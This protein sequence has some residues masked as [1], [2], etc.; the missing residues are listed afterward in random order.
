MVLLPAVRMI[1]PEREELLGPLKSALI[2]KV[3]EDEFDI[4]ELNELL[5]VD[6]CSQVLL[7]PL[8]ADHDTPSLV[9]VIS[10]ESGRLPEL[11]LLRYPANVK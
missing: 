3:V 10:L 9:I 1:D 6:T 8:A 2:Y 5:L 7:L 4:L 11:G